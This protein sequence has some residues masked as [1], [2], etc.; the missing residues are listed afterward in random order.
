MSIH[1]EN[2]TSPPTDTWGLEPLMDVAELA[3]YL[4]IPI[5]TVYDWRVHGKG[6]AAYRFGKHLKFAI[7]D[8]RAWIAQQRETASEPRRPD[9]R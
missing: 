2:L 1:N 7:S 9:R 5:S 8:V 4:G 3:A 6:P